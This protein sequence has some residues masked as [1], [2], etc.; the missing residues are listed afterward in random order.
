MTE[1]YKIFSNR[2]KTL[3]NDRNRLSQVTN[4][5]RYVSTLI[6]NCLHTGPRQLEKIRERIKIKHILTLVIEVKAL[7]QTD[8]KS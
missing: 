2:D 1:I 8:S 5:L 4:D 6:T 3:S 7:R